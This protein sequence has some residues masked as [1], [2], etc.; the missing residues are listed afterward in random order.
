VEC[1]KE[2][3]EKKD[4]KCGECKK[5]EEMSNAGRNKGKFVYSGIIYGTDSKEAKKNKYK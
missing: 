1:K 5:K 3:V 2:K 4:C